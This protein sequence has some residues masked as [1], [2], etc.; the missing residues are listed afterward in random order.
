MEGGKDRKPSLGCLHVQSEASP[1][2]P[3]PCCEGH[4]EGGGPGGIPPQRFLT[5]TMAGNPVSSASSSQ[6]LW[7]GTQSSQ[8]A[9]HRGWPAA[10]VGGDRTHSE[11]VQAAPPGDGEGDT[12]S[13]QAAAPGDGEG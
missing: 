9:P 8:A 13:P 5:G 3:C 11:A 12:G 2:P 4:P 6:G 10:G 7:R 1:Q